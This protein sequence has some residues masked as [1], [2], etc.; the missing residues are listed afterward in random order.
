[1][2]SSIKTDIPGQ[3]HFKLPFLTNYQQQIVDNNIRKHRH[4]VS[5][6]AR[7]IHSIGVR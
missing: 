6:S 7:V 5:L 1:M 2:E 3:E 4:Q